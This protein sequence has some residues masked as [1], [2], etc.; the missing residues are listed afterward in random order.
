MMCEIYYLSLEKG[1]LGGFQLEIE[2]SET[3]QYYLEML[4]VFFLCAA[5]Y[6]HIIQVD[7]AVGQ[8]QLSQHVFCIR[9]W[10]VAG[11]HYTVLKGILVNF[12]KTLGCRP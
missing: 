12:I 4:Q 8:I 2:L 9:R 11:M 3:L 10:N 5:I 7:D 6:Y 1:T